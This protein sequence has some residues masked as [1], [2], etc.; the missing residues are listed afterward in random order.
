MVLRRRWIYPRHAKAQEAL[1]KAQAVHFKQEYGTVDANHVAD[2]M[3]KTEAQGVLQE[4]LYQICKDSSYFTSNEDDQPNPTAMQFKQ[5]LGAILSA[6]SFDNTGG[7]QLNISYEKVHDDLRDSMKTYRTIPIT[8]APTSKLGKLINAWAF[9]PVMNRLIAGGNFTSGIIDGGGDGGGDYRFGVNST[10]SGEGDFIS[11]GAHLVFPI[12]IVFADDSITR[13]EGKGVVVAAVDSNKYASRNGVDL[14]DI[15]VEL[16]EGIY[17]YTDKDQA[18]FQVDNPGGKYVKVGDSVFMEQGDLVHIPT[19][20]VAAPGSSLTFQMNI[21]FARSELD[22]VGATSITPDN[23]A[24]S[25]GGYSADSG[26]E[27]GGSESDAGDGGDA[28]DGGDAEFERRVAASMA[29]Y[30]HRPICPD[31]IM[32][33]MIKAG[34]PFNDEGTEQIEYASALLLPDG[35]GNQVS[36]GCVRIGFDEAIKTN[37]KHARIAQPNNPALAWNVCFGI[38]KVPRDPYDPRKKEREAQQLLADQLAAEGAMRV[39]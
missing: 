38:L 17:T 7:N 37:L 23:T 6:S 39:D 34:V 15:G 19:D 18:Y 9:V 16:H 29:I 30:E 28:S 31:L 21:I 35:S 10:A 2:S 36:G 32:E 1:V 13:L 4:I 20:R 3:S 12:R 26:T 24:R 14:A 11:E 5:A 8:D 25:D 22:V 27:P 33:L